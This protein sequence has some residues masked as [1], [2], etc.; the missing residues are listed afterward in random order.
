MLPRRS[1]KCG[2][3]F[4]LSTMHFPIWM[5]EGERLSEMFFEQNIFLIHSYI[6]IY[7]PCVSFGQ[8]NTRR[9]RN[10]KHFCQ[11]KKI[12]HSSTSEFPV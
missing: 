7:I 5:E 3:Q 6:S 2:T 8:Q 1:L 11:N 10:D 4:G 12:L 9:P